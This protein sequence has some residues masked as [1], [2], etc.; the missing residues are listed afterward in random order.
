M[1]LVLA[2]EPALSSVFSCN[3]FSGG[4]KGIRAYLDTKIRYIC[5]QIEYAVSSETGVI[6]R[7]PDLNHFSGGMYDPILDG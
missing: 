2:E 1:N 7:T 6:F 3:A 5:Q 4:S